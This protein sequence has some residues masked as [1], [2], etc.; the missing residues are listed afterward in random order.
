M[1][2]EISGGL[3]NLFLLHFVTGVVFGVIYMFAPETYAQL[4]DWPLREVPPYRLIGAAL[5][6]FGISS[7]L[8][9]KSG[10]WEEVKIVVFAEIVWCGLAG[11]L[12]VWSMF[13]EGLPAIG[14]LNTGLL[15]FFAAA[16]T[17]FYQK[18]K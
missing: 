9:Y 17:Y 8:A 7:W 10:I 6:G 1:G 14:W 2:K 15:L 16:F 18:E 4:V 5:C 13:A 11:I 12:M 3:K